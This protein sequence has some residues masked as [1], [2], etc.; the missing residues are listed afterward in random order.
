MNFIN[1][2]DKAAMQ[3]RAVFL[4]SL[5]SN[6]AVPVAA[7]PKIS[8]AIPTFNRLLL[9]QR[10]LDSVLKQNYPNLEIIVSDNASEDGTREF[11]DRVSDPRVKVLRHQSNV[12]MVANWDSCLRVATG[13]YF[14]LMSDDDALEDSSAIQEFVHAFNGEYG[15]EVGIVFSDVLF[16]RSDGIVLETKSGK[17][18]LYNSIDLITSVLSNEISVFPCATVFRTKDL[19][20]LGG[21]GV[22]QA[23]LAVD[24]CAWMSVALKYGSVAR[25]PKPLSI[26]R[27]HQSL[28][29]SSVEI[30]SADYMAMCDVINLR[31]TQIP[32]HKV[33]SLEKAMLSAW[34]GVPLGY[35]S[36]RLRYDKDFG[37]LDSLKEIFK[38]RSRIFTTTNAKL[39]FQRL[40]R[41]MRY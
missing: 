3:T 12:G 16:E 25:V 15:C 38:Y 24:A 40:L 27:V 1:S 36:R 37:I 7:L 9:L 29:S 28:S 4:P 32:E 35:L 26:Y 13:T 10:S 22:F 20:D 18:T 41:S 11:L 21:Y 19:T 33:R 8:V 30:W 6:T 17:Q 34:N 5:K 2:R 23:T 31:T 39:V 14:L